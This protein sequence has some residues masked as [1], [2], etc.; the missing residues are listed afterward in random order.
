MYVPIALA[1]LLAASGVASSPS[2][3]TWASNTMPTSTFTPLKLGQQNCFDPY[4][5]SPVVDPAHQ[6]KLISKACAPLYKIGPNTPSLVIDPDD[7]ER[8]VTVEETF[9]Q[10][11]ETI[12]GGPPGYSIQANAPDGKHVYYYKVHWN[13]KCSTTVPEQR[14]WRPID[15]ADGSA[16]CKKLLANDYL[17]CKNNGGIGGWIDAGCLRYVFTV[18]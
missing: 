4:D 11:A 9:V 7:E 16:D 14:P 12:E 8:N 1:A 2:M 3:T 10:G 17:N 5:G 15:V 13:D 18:G 6:Q